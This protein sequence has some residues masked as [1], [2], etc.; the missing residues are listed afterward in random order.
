MH[1]VFLAPAFLLLAALAA[2]LPFLHKTARR[3][4]LRQASLVIWQRLQAT[5]QETRFLRKQPSLT[6]PMMLQMACFILF[7]LALARPVLDSHPY[8]TR[9]VI[10]V[11]NAGLDMH[12][13]L[14]QET[15]FSNAKAQ[16][17]SQLASYDDPDG[18]LLSLILAGT[19]PQIIFARQP[20]HPHL[21]D[22]SQQELTIE[23]AQAD[24]QRTAHLLSLLQEENELTNIIL[25]TSD[26]GRDLQNEIQSPINVKTLG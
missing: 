6:W 13:R 11:L 23:D 18:P 16:I 8:Q 20:Y 22:A 14:E 19:K 12:Q 2:L 26:E 17:R 5:A 21:W 4:K 24:W 15:L 25:F 10:Y 7:A 9:H 1:L 3:T